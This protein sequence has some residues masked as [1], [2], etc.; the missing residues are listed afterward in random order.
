VG[1]ERRLEVGFVCT[2]AALALRDFD[3][4]RPIATNSS[5]C[6]LHEQFDIERAA[7]KALGYGSKRGLLGRAATSSISK[8]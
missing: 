4:V 2:G 8:L 5:L 1:I 7:R 3:C 6:L